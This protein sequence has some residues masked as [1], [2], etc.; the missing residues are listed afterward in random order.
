MQQNNQ[1]NRFS[2]APWFESIQ[3]STIM[4]LG[5]GGVGSWLS[6]FLTRAGANVIVVDFD[7]VEDINLAGQLYGPKQIGKPKV[8]ALQEVVASLNQT[9]YYTAINEKVT[10]SEKDQWVQY[11]PICDITVVGFDNLATRQLVYNKWAKKGKEGSLFLDMRMSM[12]QGNIFTVRQGNEAD[13]AAYEGSFFPESEA[14]AE[15]CSAKAT[16]HCGAFIASTTMSVLTNWFSDKGDF[17]SVPRR[18]DFFL[19]ILNFETQ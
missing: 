12:E 10:E 2:A 18:L 1:Y 4:I 17:R 9:I 19:P 16:S 13:K 7:T 5:A 8:T 14:V 3:K 11:L 15:P 6:L